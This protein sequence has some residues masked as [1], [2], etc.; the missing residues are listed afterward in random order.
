MAEAAGVP[1]IVHYREV[2]LMG[3]IS[4]LKHLGKLT[5]IGRQVQA[6]MRAFSP[7]V[8]IPVDF[9]DFNF[10]F[11]LPYAHEELH[12]P[13]TYYI[14]PK[15]WAWRAGRIRTLRRYVDLGL[16]ILPFET[17]Y[18]ADR[19]LPTLY[20]GNPCVD[21]QLTYR[22]T[23]TTETEREQMLLLVPGSRKS[24]L[25]DNLPQ[26]L[27]ATVPYTASGWR[28]VIAGAPGL[29]AEDYAPYLTT[30]SDIPILFGDTYGLMRRAHLA[31][32]TS[33]T[34]TLEAGLWGVPMVV[35]YRM[36]GKRIARYV[37]EHFFRVPYFS[38]VNLI[39]DRPAVPELLADRA[40][41][42]EIRTTLEQLLPTESPQ[43]TQQIQ[44]L[45][46]LQQQM[47]NEPSA[48]RAAR[49]ICDHLRQR[50]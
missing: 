17:S 11:I 9:A 50:R 41:A 16:S 18:F 21:A 15:L 34:A 43:R 4:V 29:T 49:A 32:V 20:I 24:E 27:E 1:P 12:C 10:R 28:I 30:H 25:R 5:R 37:F 23:H 13:V 31:L 47:G 36:G 45:A 46:E 3:I 42:S 33:G 7:D 35:C 40:R 8:V 48:P 39:L 14:L 26:M 38:L 19:G 22:S 2:A 44:A 6:A